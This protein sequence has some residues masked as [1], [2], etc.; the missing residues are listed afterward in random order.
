MLIFY[1]NDEL[2]YNSDLKNNWDYTILISLLVLIETL[3]FQFIFYNNDLKNPMHQ[4]L[5][6]LLSKVVDKSVLLWFYIN[7]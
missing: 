4:F 3:Y 2:G 5:P 1:L 6:L 7:L